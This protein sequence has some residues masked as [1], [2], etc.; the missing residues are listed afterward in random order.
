[1]RGLMLLS[2]TL[3][4]LAWAAPGRRDGT[5]PVDFGIQP[6]VWNGVGYLIDTAKEARVV[7]KP[8]SELDLG[9]L[10]PGDLILAIQPEHLPAP[11]ELVRFV[12][13]G[14]Y[15][16]L[17]AEGPAY[18]EVFEAF[19]VRTGVV[20]VETEALVPTPIAATSQRAGKRLAESFLFFNVDEIHTNFP[21]FLQVIGRSARG[22]LAWPNGA[23]Y[24]VVEVRVGAGAALIVSDAS[25]FI[26]QMLRQHYGNKQFAANALRYFCEREPC[27]AWFVGGDG[28][29]SGHFDEDMARFGPLQRAIRA[30]VERVNE[31]VPKV[32]PLGNDSPWLLAFLL[33]GVIPLCLRL[34]MTS[35]GPRVSASSLAQTAPPVEM[36]H[37]F[38]AR[39]GAADFGTL[40]LALAEFAVSE[41]AR[42]GNRNRQRPPPIVAGALARLESDAHRLRERNAAGVSS[43]FFVRVQGDVEAVLDYLRPRG[44]PT[45]GQPTKRKERD[46]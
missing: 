2:A 18:S 21:E 8:V 46:V 3:S 31:A 17:A 36:A 22:V 12:S 45:R 30:F 37:A 23:Q 7:L 24:L 13:A 15:L 6:D 20:P 44:R 42:G 35:R 25:V 28:G 38:A 34:A 39:R 29:V 4:A 9:E 32:L 27:T 10:E 26:N 14:G 1:M 11:D 43:E 19:G 5:T 33:L 40:A 41:A 16:I